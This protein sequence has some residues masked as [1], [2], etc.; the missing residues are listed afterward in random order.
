MPAAFRQSIARGSQPAVV[1]LV[2]FAA[3]KTRVGKLLGYQS[4]DG[5]LSVENETGETVEGRDWIKALA[6]EWAEEDGRK[7]SKDVLHLSLTLPPTSCLSDDEV[8]E[9]LKVA[10]AGHRIAWQRHMAGAG[11]GRRVELVI[12]AARRRLADEKR[13]GRIFDNRK[14]LRDLETRLK[15]A[16]GAE[17][18]VDV[19]GFSHGV[20]GVARGLGQLQKDGR[21]PIIAV[22]MDKAGAFVAQHE[23]GGERSIADEAR[24]W[25]QDLRSQ[26]RRDVAHIVLS[27]KPGTAKEAFV[28]AARAML[29]SEFSGHRFL[30]T[31]HEDRNH[32][33]VHAVVKMVSETGKRLHPKIEDLRR[34]RAVL[35]HEARER[36]IPMDA[37]SR[38]E[39]ANPPGFKMKD[40]RRVE[41]GEASETVMRRVEAVRQQAVHIPTRAEG[42]RRAMASAAGWSGHLQTAETDPAEPPQRPGTTRLYRVQRDNDRSAAPLFTVDRAAAA[43]ILARQ[44]GTL[45]YIDVTSKQ[46]QD[47]RPSRL[48]PEAVFVVP[49]E[50][51]AESQILS[52]TALE[53]A[54]LFRQRTLDAVLNGATAATE[55]NARELLTA[56]E[57][58]MADLE[59]M[60]SAFAEM[61]T[62]LDTL[63]KNLPPER[64]AEFDGLRQKLKVNQTKMIEAQT[65]IEAKRGRIEGETWVQ[66]VP[67]NFV[68]F[69]AEKRGED[70]RYSHRAPEGRIGAVAFTD[71]GDRVEVSRSRDRETVLAA[72][73]LGAEKWGAV[74]VSGPD[75]YKVL[76]V[77]LAAE[78]GFQLTNP[79]LQDKL[80]SARDR[81]ARERPEQASVLAGATPTLTLADRRYVE[82][83]DAAHLDRAQAPDRRDT[84]QAS[85]PAAAAR[86]KREEQTIVPEAG[87][88][89]EVAS[90]QTLDGPKTPLDKGDKVKPSDRD[91]ASILEAMQVA[92]EKWGVVAVNGSERDKTIAVEFAAE[93]GFKLSNP[94]LQERLAAARSKVEERQE[95]ERARERKQL[96]FVDGA[97]AAPTVRRSD[98]EI[99]IALETVKEK[100]EAE[101]AREVKQAKRTAQIGERPIDGGG[102]DHTY[103]TKAEAS[104]AVRA[105]KF[106]E[107]NPTKP[108][109]ADVAQSPEIERQR[110]DQ[111]EL[112]SEKDANR[113]TQVRKQK[114]RQRR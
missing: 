52:V 66:P 45:R 41:R 67:Q 56:K 81:I 91:R 59:T 35:A 22:R 37:V 76:A 85:S 16:F 18:R 33:H 57:P 60:S 48:N 114:P 39:R 44:G 74:R 88:K 38:F 51:A 83:A 19:H 23:V 92:S 77:E 54:G 27:A 20:E 112:L 73:Q 106:I 29:A 13:A 15:R 58:G 87:A 113:Q 94:E 46:R 96:G 4:R 17:A 47:I 36:N 105:E 42:V 111:K 10:L 12:S 11:E 79:E 21:H 104:A 68:G 86:Q 53:T 107:Q 108:I 5:E 28:G 49:R 30:F 98:A 103:R 100:T 25:K 101:A 97:E 24:D 110:L 69:V 55:R 32:L 1:K 62:N 43:Q 9:V 90:A 40:I 102:D 63:A 72:L 95:R 80:A 50:L 7:P 70:I 89:G 84:V 71:H 2:S 31:L 93:H 61:E 14:S 3:G 109:P 6:N 99:G 65:A 78:H 82:A 34:W 64:L 75:R 26:Q 8:G